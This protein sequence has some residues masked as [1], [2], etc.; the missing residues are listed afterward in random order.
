MTPVGQPDIGTNSARERMAMSKL[1][2]LGNC[3]AFA[4]LC[5]GASPAL[6]ETKPNIVA[7][8]TDNQGYGDVGV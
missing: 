4:V 1:V 8:M 5:V 6:A 2:S 3:I 7:I